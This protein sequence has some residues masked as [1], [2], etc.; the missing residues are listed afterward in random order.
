MLTVIA[1][2]Y[3]KVVG[4]R[5]YLYD[6]GVLDTVA[7]G[8]HTVSIGN[9]T[10]GGTGKTP[11]VAYVA[12]LLAERGE[13]VCVLTRGYKRKDERRRVLVSDGEKIHADAFTAGD[14][15]YELAEKLLGKAIVIADADRVS[16]GE[17]AKRK[18][19]VTAFVL[20]DAFQHRRV[21][22]D[23]DILCVDGSHPFGAGKLLPKGRLREPV[24][25]L[26]RADIVVIVKGHKDL[27]YQP[28]RNDIKR[29]ALSATTFEAERVLKRISP[30]RGADQTTTGD[31]D[32]AYFAF[33]GLANPAAFIVSL[34]EDGLRVIAAEALDDHHRYTQKE[35]HVI[36]KTARAAGAASLITTVKDAV[37]LRDLRFTMTCLVAE[38][39]LEIDDPERFAKLV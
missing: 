11:L 16:A 28:L 29:T 25:G 26:S 3:G 17:W 2:A 35:I 6:R 30:V 27:S 32:A 38:M 20:D 21:R 23:V 4:L 36:E 37:K 33:C 19:G 9:I 12:K 13:K 34:K 24:G 22:R 39:E 14:E 15:P 5:N 31:R 1:W 18:F 7:L 8:A 10:T